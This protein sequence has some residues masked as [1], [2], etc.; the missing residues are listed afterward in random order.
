MFNSYMYISNF[1]IGKKGDRLFNYILQI[2]DKEL[3][4]LSTYYKSNLKYCAKISTSSIQQTN[5]LINMLKQFTWTIEITKG[6][7]T[8]KD[9]VPLTLR[10]Y[11]SKE[12]T[13]IHIT[14]EHNPLELKDLIISLHK[15]PIKVQ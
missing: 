7:K 1:T 2:S 6:I 10:K 5:L 15:N 12:I 9:G 14:V 4:L 8:Y 13:D 11:L 3:I